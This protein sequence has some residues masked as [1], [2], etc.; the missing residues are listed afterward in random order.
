[1]SDE[2]PPMFGWAI[3]GRWNYS[4]RR[5]F[6]V[7]IWRTR[8]EAIAAHISDKGRSW[9]ECRK[10]GDRFVRVVMKEDR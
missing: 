9:E 6:Y 8:S 5:Y 1:M 10:H 7:G 3:A 4:G 2:L